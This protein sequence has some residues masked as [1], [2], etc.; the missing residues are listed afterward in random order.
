MTFESKTSNYEIGIVTDSTAYLSQELIEQHKLSV[1]PVQ[2][3]I[4]GEAF[5]DSTDLLTSK[6]IPA[7]RSNQ[8]VTTARPSVQT[9]V[10][11]YQAQ[12][13]A[14][15]KSILSIHL[16]SELSGT[17]ES[18]VL[19]AR[20]MNVPVTVVDSRGV[21]GFLQLVVL[22]AVRLRSQGLEISEIENVL[23][24]QCA[25]IK[26]YFYVDTLEFLE[27]GGRLSAFKS[28]VGQ[29]L[30]VKPILKMQDGKVE[31]QEL[32][33]S[34]TKALN[35]IID[36]A[37]DQGTAHTFLINHIA[38]PDRALLISEA[39][40][41]ELKIEPINIVTAGAVVGAHVGPG[42]VAVVID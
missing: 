7:L 27:R 4:D 14:G 40:S 21:A 39:I 28:K 36:L 25:R 17:Y 5:S 26:M 9:F 35:R 24:K 10:E 32:V 29:F 15:A 42:T 11:I 23:T 2:V 13:S 41:D 3:I 20:Q 31:L 18:A 38:S 37:C 1:V 34:E 16:S 30:T 6:V 8:T 12:V 33:R 22:N 19:A